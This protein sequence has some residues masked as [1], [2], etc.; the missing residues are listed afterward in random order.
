M[1]PPLS[2][3][4]TT[5]AVMPVPAAPAPAPAA[6]VDDATA[7]HQGYPAARYDSLWTKSPFAVETAE[8]NVEESPDYSLVGVARVDG[9]SYAASSTSRTPPFPRLLRQASNGLALTSV[10]KSPTSSD[11][12]AVLTQGRRAAYPQARAGDRRH[13]TGAGHERQRHAA[14][15]HAHQRGQRRRHAF[16]AAMIRMH[17]PAHSLAAARAGADAP[18]AAPAVGDCY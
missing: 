14:N 18:A 4:A 17:R 3:T 12:Y 13:R 16:L 10:T 7:S 8:T 9:I 15:D 2:I 1:P 11:I 6:P 5:A